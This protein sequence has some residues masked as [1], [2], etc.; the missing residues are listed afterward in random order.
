MLFIYLQRKTGFYAKL[1]VGNWDLLF[2]WSLGLVWKLP[3]FF[4]PFRFFHETCAKHTPD[5]KWINFEQITCFH[6]R[7]RQK[8]VSP[9]DDINNTFLPKIKFCNRKRILVLRSYLVIISIT[10]SLFKFIISQKFTKISVLSY[11]SFRSSL[12]LFSSNSR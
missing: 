3:L 1:R 9:L 11:F 8:P 10:I 6:P 5:P 7:F 4:L 12:S 2:M